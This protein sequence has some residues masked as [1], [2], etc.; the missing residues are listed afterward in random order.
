MRR[1]F[2]RLAAACAFAVAMTAFTGSAFAGNGNGSGADT[3]PGQ[4]KKDQAAATETPAPAAAQALQQ[5]QAQPPGQAKK[6]QSTSSTQSSTQ[7]GVK[8]D[9]KTTKWTHCTTGG[10]VGATTCT[11]SDNGHTPQ[12]NVD[13]SKRYGNGKTAAQIV[14]SRGGIGVQL[15]GPGNSQ[16][17]K[18]TVCGK[19]SN[20]SGGVDVH[21]VKSYPPAGCTQTTHAAATALQAP[22][23]F[24]VVATMSEAGTP[25]G[26][27]KG[28]SHNKHEKSTTSFSLQPDSTQSCNS[29]GVTPATQQSAAVAPVTQAASPVLRSSSPATQSSTAAPV[30]KSAAGGVLGVQTTLKSP[31]PA[32][33]GV[34]GTVTNVAGSSLPF[35]GFPVWLAIVLAVALI[36]AGLALRRRGAATRA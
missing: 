21:A 10:S 7:L 24:V 20:K 16:P 29:A 1:P 35:T 8:P 33:G 4:Q 14:V 26:H 36:L 34:L 28:L 23:G 18:V 25:R 22:C 6:L 3:A 11:S 9:S 32:R 31:K 12:P 5:Q 17:H 2:L 15:T 13:A 19:P 27:G 30:T